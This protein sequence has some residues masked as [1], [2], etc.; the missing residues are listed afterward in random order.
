[1]SRPAPRVLNPSARSLK[2]RTA[3]DNAWFQGFVKAMK[4][5]IQAATLLLGMGVAVAQT[6]EVRV[7][8]TSTNESIGLGKEGL[9]LSLPKGGVELRPLDAPI[10][11]SNTPAPLSVLDEAFREPEKPPTEGAAAETERWV[12]LALNGLSEASPKA[13]VI[14]AGGIEIGGPLINALHVSKPMGLPK[15]LLHLVD[16]FAPMDQSE[17]PPE[18]EGSNP[19]AWTSLVGWSPGISAF[20]DPRTH[21]LSLD[22]VSVG[23]AP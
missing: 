8:A 17:E 12:S 18:V 10:T 9:A 1:M 16:P 19:L 3:F 13:E 14:Q 4:V 21:T 23:L 20:A 22:L 11:F 2:L 6:Q 7:A 15:R 5:I